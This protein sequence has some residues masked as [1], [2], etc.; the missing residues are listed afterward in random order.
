MASVRPVAAVAARDAFLLLERGGWI[1]EQVVEHL[2]G[3][4]QHPE[5]GMRWAAA[6]IMAEIGPAW[7]GDIKPLLHALTDPDENVRMAVIETLGEFRDSRAA[8]ALL[9]GIGDHH[10]G[11][12]CR[13]VQ[14][15]A[16]IGDERVAGALIPLLTDT[17]SD[18]RL[19]TVQTLGQLKNRVVLDD[20]KAVLSDP[21]R[22]VRWAAAQAIQDIKI[23]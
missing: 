11:V 8:E 1:G 23:G 13:I 18:V 10:S 9:Q 7:I 6:R 19:L 21:D 20:L 5:G 16:K 22:S 2:V 17:D 3:L 12:R 4:L 15:L 14:A